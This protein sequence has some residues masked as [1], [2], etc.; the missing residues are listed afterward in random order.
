MLKKI[1]AKL[2]LLT[3]GSTLLSILLISFIMNIAIFHRYNRYL[4]NEQM[5]AH[6]DIIDLV[7][8][9]YRLN[10]G[11]KSDAIDIIN[12]SPIIHNY[13]I[14]I[15]DDNDKFIYEHILESSMID[16]HNEMMGKMGHAMMGRDH[17]ARTVEEG[18]YTVNKYNLVIDNNLIGNIEIGSVGPYL[19]SERDIEFTR[20]INTSIALAAIISILVA[21]LLGIYSSRIFST[22]VMKITRAAN[23]MRRGILD[24]QVKLSD[25]TVELQELVDSINHLARTLN[26]QQ[27]LRKR[28][29]ADISHELR[30]PLTILQS[31]IEAIN[32]GIW[33]ATPD[34]LNILSKEVSRLIKLVEELKYLADIEN[35]HLELNIKR[36]NLSILLQEVAD[37]FKYEFL[38]KGIAL[39]TSITSEVLVEADQDKLKQ[40]FI[41]LLSNAL[42]FTNKGGIADVNLTTD[43]DNALVAIKDTGIGIEVKDIP[44]IFERF[45]R[46]DISR[47]RKSGG[48][49][50]GLTIVETLVEA[51]SGKVY[52]ESK[53]GEGS[54]FTVLLPKVSKSTYD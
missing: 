12:F 22:P 42:K 4:E 26:Q 49:G 19:I 27:D 15:K 17:P 53:P 33:E 34:K 16:V 46:S 18:N 50:I 54:V 23:D 25:N 20:G 9:S 48:A 11:W 39:R 21:I 44:Y 40:V 14:V 3:V 2:I 52:V 41:N 36:I 38:T 6:Q 37:S 24:V 8:K 32:D 31:H 1:R 7:I 10:N 51:H 5:Q 13:D 28:L 47:N 43:K 29:T 30:T 35:H 45:Y